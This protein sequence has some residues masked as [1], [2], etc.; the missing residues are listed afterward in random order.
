MA[1]K[2]I[3]ASEAGAR[4]MKTSVTIAVSDA[5]GHLVALARM[6]GA[7]FGSLTSAQRKAYTG[8]GL[9]MSTA[10]LEKAIVAVPALVSA[11]GDGFTLLG[12]GLPIVKGGQLIG[13]IGIAGGSSEQ[14]SQIAAAGL[15]A[16]EQM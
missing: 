15:T 5:G 14:D 8:A 16:L 4:A 11:L 6:D 3:E 10:I 9:A 1:R 2:I 12:G 13:A 7:S